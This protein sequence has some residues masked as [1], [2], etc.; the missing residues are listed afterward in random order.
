MFYSNAGGNVTP[1]LLRD[2]AIVL[3]KGDVANVA[4][5]DISIDP[6]VIGIMR[7]FLLR[8]NDAVPVSAST[9]FEMRVGDSVS[10]YSG[11]SGYQSVGGRAESGFSY[12]YGSD[13]GLA[14][15]PSN[16]AMSDF[17]VLIATN[18]PALAQLRHITFQGTYR[19]SSNICSYWGAAVYN[20]DID[21]TRLRIM[22][23]TGNISKMKYLLMGWP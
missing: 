19:A 17:E 10:I 22:F 13:N 15:T 3:A 18:D 5:V 6:A 16:T 9:F 14:L 12:Y 23:G 4:F 8:I 1:R 20:T 11:S 21:I 2:Y 7:G